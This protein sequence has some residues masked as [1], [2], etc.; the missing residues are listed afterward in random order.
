MAT[1]IL[2]KLSKDLA[3]KLQ[4]PVT[5]GTV[6]GTRLT[7]AN[8]LGYLTRAYRRLLRLVTML[9]PELISK[10][11]NS[12]YVITTSDTDNSGLKSASTYAEV[13]EVYCKEPND[14]NYVKATYIIAEQFLS[15]LTGYNEFYKPNINT[16]TYYWSMMDGSIKMAPEVKFNLKLSYKKNIASDIE[17]GGYGGAT[18]FDLPTEH[19]DL[20]LSLAA[21]EA[22]LD[23]AQFN[24]V[25]AYKSDVTDQLKILVNVSKKAEAEDENN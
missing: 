13:H 21:G 3:Y 5:I 11:F 9:Y 10:L 20:L 19:T 18:D 2:E 7:A 4:D 23:I 17:D 6:D 1:P 22:Y 14:E 15:V 24:M 16:L 8:R 25:N 12:Y